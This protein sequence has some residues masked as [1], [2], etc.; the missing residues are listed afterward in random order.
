[1]SVTTPRM[2]LKG[3]AVAH[4]D[5]APLWPPPDGALSLVL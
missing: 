3:P 5:P 4:L 1:M 2:D